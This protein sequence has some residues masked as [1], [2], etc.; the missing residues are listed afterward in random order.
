ME[1][2]RPSIVCEAGHTDD[3]LLLTLEHNDRILQT[4]AGQTRHGVKV[5]LDQVER[6]GA[7]RGLRTGGD[8]SDLLLTSW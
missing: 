3:V 4:S 7:V 5:R 8:G 2:H 6:G 1:E